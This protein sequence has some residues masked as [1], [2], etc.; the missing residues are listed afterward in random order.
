MSKEYDLLII[1]SGPAGYVGAV[2]ASQLGLKCGVIEKGDVGGVCLNIGCIPS[3]ALI[4]QAELFRGGEELEAMGIGVDRS[5]FDYRKVWKK[6]RK[7]STSLSKGVNYLLKKNGIDLITGEAKLKGSGKVEVQG[8]K[9]KEEYSAPNIL[10]ASGSSPRELDDF[11]F[12]GKKVISSDDALM[13]EELPASIAILGAGAIGC[14][15][16]HIMASFGVKV[17]LI[18]AMERILPLE[19]PETTEVLAR[20][21]KKRKIEMVTGA[22]AKSV[23]TT[24]EGITLTLETGGKEEQI[25]AEK[26][27]VVVGR[28][29][30]TGGL[31]L[32]DAGIELDEKGFVKTGACYQAA[33][34]VY[35]AGDLIGG[36]LLAHVASK[37]AEIAVEHI[38]GEKGPERLDPRLAPSAVYTE[39]EIAGFGLSDAAAKEKGFETESVQFPYKG[40]GK[41][42]AIEQSDGFVK[43]I[44]DKKTREILGARIVGAHATELIHELLLARSSELLPEDIAHMV[45][46]HPTLSEAVMEAARTAE[47]WAIHA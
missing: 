33:D 37:E 40:A 19:D 5:S 32:E 16:A 7:A 11:P 47:G 12:D 36:M 31:G 15:F 18:E 27:L 17:T 22:K 35:A 25:K 43:L 2:R 6:S 42:V 46:A 24:K 14:E 45:H 23:K 9:G 34:G 26:L 4:R 38:A 30:N 21:F 20:S 44:F 3:K 29:P 1:G 8:E 41:S 39:P 10:L 28:S 13:M